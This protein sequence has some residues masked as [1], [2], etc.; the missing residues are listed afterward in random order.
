MPTYDGV[1]YTKIN[2]LPS[3]KVAPGQAAGVSFTAYDE[4]TSLVNLV[5]ADII[6]TGVK[7]PKGAKV[8]RLVVVSP[9]NGGSVSA[10]ITGTATKYVNAG[11]AGATTA[12]HPLVDT[13][14]E[15]NVILTI[16]GS[17]SATGTYKVFVEYLKY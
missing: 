7:I 2:A 6:N 8:V 15:E 10:G 14:A 9:A 12:V 3:E 5:A 11:T 4:Y 17:P 13:T 16:G 1:N